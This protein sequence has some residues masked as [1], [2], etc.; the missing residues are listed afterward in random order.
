[1]KIEFLRSRVVD[2]LKSASDAPKM[3]AYTKEGFVTHVCT[4]MEMWDDE[5][6]VADFYFRHLSEEGADGVR[7]RY[8]TVTSNF[9]D[10]WAQKVVADAMRNM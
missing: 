9:E 4:V 1:M 7:V 8:E 3:F 2:V 5:F 6:D 10:E